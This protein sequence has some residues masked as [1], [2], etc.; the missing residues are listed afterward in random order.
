MAEWDYKLFW[1]ETLNQLRE[2][3]GNE[4]FSRW[5]KLVEYLGAAE[6]EIILGVPSNFYRD[7]VKNRYQSQIK[8]ALKLVAGQDIGLA[9]K[10]APQNRQFSGQAESAAPPP[11]SG[12]VRQ[13]PGETKPP[14]QKVQPNLFSP[15]SAPAQTLKAK[16]PRHPQLRE[17]Y[18]FERYVIGENNNFAANAA[19]AISRNPG[20]VYNPFLIYGGVGL[21]KTHLM[22]SIGNYV[23]RHS[24]LKIIYITTENFINEFIKAIRDKQTPAFKNKY[25]FADLLLIDDIQFLGKKWET[26]DELFHTFNALYDANKHII[27]TCD[28]PASELKEINDRLRSR[29]ERGLNVDL[30]P[31]DYET[32]VAILKSKL[33]DRRVDISD[34]VLDLIAQNVTTNVRELEAALTKLTAYA[35]L[36]GKPVTLESARQQLKYV[37]ASSPEKQPSISI[38]TIVKV[39]AQRFSLS[40]ND[41][42]SNKRTQKIAL[43]R[44]IAMYIAREITEFSTT[45]IGQQFEGRHY[46]TVMHACEKIENQCRS[47]PSLEST[48]QTI[49]GIIKEADNSH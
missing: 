1:D 46:S 36:L 21:G 13:S 33:L 16:K 15:D 35:G 20:T 24:D 4:E 25:R 39:T 47:D 43:P 9:F 23:H 22:Q 32:R 3:I 28:R 49:I 42:K 44:Q 18:T 17:D 19:I 37:F 31:P 34:A 27:F 6:L 12:P 48:I 7:Q 10:V 5:F 41:L 38:E 29:F 2:A 40:P 45:E 26:Q 11:Q 14:P 8:A 30:Q